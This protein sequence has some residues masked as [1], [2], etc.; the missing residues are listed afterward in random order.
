MRNLLCLLLVLFTAWT[1]LSHGVLAKRITLNQVM[2][3]EEQ[4]ATGVSRLSKQERD[5]L[6]GWLTEWALTWLNQAPETMEVSS[7]F[8]DFAREKEKRAVTRVI[9][10]GTQ[11]QLN[12]DSVWAIYSVDVQ[13]V[14]NWLPKDPV[15]VSR[16]GDYAYP[17]LL[18]NQSTGRFA[19][20]QMLS[21]PTLDETPQQPRKQYVRRKLRVESVHENGKF[22]TLTDNS[23]WEIS[24]ADRPHSNLWLH[25]E[26]VAIE[27]SHDNFYPYRIKNKHSGEEALA[28]LRQQGGGSSGTPL[29]LEETPQKTTSPLEAGKGFPAPNP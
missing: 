13:E 17:Y 12:D 25:H 22:V 6:E 9:S 4:Q 8:T 20:A 15:D 26:T 19:K 1:H 14:R 28:K 21:F 10:N 3:P 18:T 7:S 23:V 2:S 27:R 24:P 5:A 29:P 11:L 16:S